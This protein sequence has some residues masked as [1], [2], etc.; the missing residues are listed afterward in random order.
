MK[1]IDL[2][3]EETLSFYYSNPFQEQLG[4][5]SEYQGAVTIPR[6]Y[7]VVAKKANLVSYNYNV[8]VSQF[9]RV[10][11][12]SLPRIESIDIVNEAKLAIRSLAPL[13][14]SIKHPSVSLVHRQARNY[15]HWLID[16]LPRSLAALH[17]AQETGATVKVI[18]SDSL[19]AWQRRSLQ[20]IGIEQADLIPVSPPTKKPL[21][22]K[23]DHAIFLRSHSYSF[24][25]R[26]GYRDALSPL[27]FRSMKERITKRA[28]ISRAE[29]ACTRI[30]ILRKTFGSADRR[31]IE[32]MAEL[33]NLLEPFGFLFL[34]LEDLTFDEQVAFFTD[35]SHIIAVHGS[36]LANLMFSQ[37]A[38]ILEIFSSGHG[39]RPEY[40]QLS[41]MTNCTYSHFV[42]PTSPPHH[43]VSIPLDK[44]KS[45]LD[46]TL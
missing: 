46:M 10:I 5:L 13:S 11:L 27:F 36:G 7:Y 44:V 45:F 16:Y 42:V 22:I 19:S 2:Y 9:K 25:L 32:N 37:G 23:L 28:G 14:H 15:F 43:D 26:Y 6:K 18:V 41:V 38:H 8:G 1:Y 24:D 17:F 33:K 30:F 12:E 34:F 39:V 40:W 31:F 20:L 35:A 4:R 21:N 3:P 29:K